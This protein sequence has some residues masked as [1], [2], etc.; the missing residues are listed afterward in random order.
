VATHVLVACV[1][2]NDHWERCENL[3]RSL[4]MDNINVATCRCSVTSSEVVDHKNDQ[5]ANRNKRN[6]GSILQT[7]EPAQE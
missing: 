4:Y 1:C 2:K 3:D 7:V 5:I 6:D